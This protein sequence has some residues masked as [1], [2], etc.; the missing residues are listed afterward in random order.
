MSILY[1]L[2][3]PG[4]FLSD[5]KKGGI[6]E[7]GVELWFWYPDIRSLI[8]PFPQSGRGMVEWWNGNPRIKRLAKTGAQRIP[9]T[10]FSSVKAQLSMPMMQ[11]RP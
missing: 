4:P 9:R 2:P 6:V 8:P 3:P 1:Q 10:A 5:E 11:R 7:L